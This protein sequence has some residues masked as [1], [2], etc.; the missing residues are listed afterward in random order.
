MFVDCATNAERE[1]EVR[2]LFTV[3]KYVSYYMCSAAEIYNI[4]IVG[5]LNPAL[6]AKTAF[7]TADTVEQALEMAFQKGGRQ[8]KIY[9]AP[10]G[11]STLPKL[12]NS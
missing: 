3:P 5:G 2:N 11:S 4:I 12:R 8:Q 9:L 1:R 10:Q 7:P 6:L